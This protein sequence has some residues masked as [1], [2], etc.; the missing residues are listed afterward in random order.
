MAVRHP[1][2][3]VVILFILL[4][5][6]LVVASALGAPR[7]LGK[8]WGKEIYIIVMGGAFVYLT[9]SD[10]RRKKGT[11]HHVSPAEEGILQ[12]SQN[13]SS[14]VSNNQLKLDDLKWAHGDPRSNMMTGANKFP[15]DQ[16]CRQEQRA[17]PSW[18]V[19]GK[20]SGG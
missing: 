10:R 7:I 18:R 2:D 1:I 15:S 4:V 13:L 6:S 20:T 17:V 5:A 14:Q 8:Y 19:E 12:R 3:L 16:R 11:V 9:L